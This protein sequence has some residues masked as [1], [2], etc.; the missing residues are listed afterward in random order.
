MRLRIT[1]ISLDW[2]YEQYKVRD[3]RSLD[4]DDLLEVCQND[5][6]RVNPV[7][8]FKNNRVVGF[9]HRATIKAILSAFTFSEYVSS[10]YWSAKTRKDMKKMRFMADMQE[11]STGRETFQQYA[12]YG[13]GFA[14]LTPGS[15]VELEVPRRWVE[16]VLVGTPENPK[17]MARYL[18]V[19]DLDERKE[20]VKVS[21]QVDLPAEARVMP[22]ERMSFNVLRDIAKRKGMNTRNKTKQ[23]VL[24]FLLSL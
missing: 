24:E 18:T 8:R 3:L 21:E 16:D 17:G 11:H 23:E 19:E 20:F 1:N 4:E 10:D 2:V 6:I 22:Y 7:F 5:K 14:D 12:F 13:L 15:S 9:D